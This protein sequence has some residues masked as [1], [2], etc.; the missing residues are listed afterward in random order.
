V[1]KEGFQ[2]VAAPPEESKDS[3]TFK[4]N[5]GGFL[6]AGNSRTLAFTAAADYLLRRGPSQFNVLAAVN[7]GRSSPGAG[8]PSKDTVK[9]Y[10]ARARYDY[11]FVGPLAGFLSV[12]A[13]KDKFM[14]LDLRLNIDPGVAYY[15]IDE[16]DHRFWAELGYDLQYDQRQD[17]YVALTLADD[18]LPDVKDSETSHSARLFAGYVNQLLAAVKFN[19]GIEYLQDVKDTERARLNIDLGLTSQLSTTFS[20]A[21][22]L[23][24][25]YDNAPLPGVEKTDVLSALNLVYTFSQ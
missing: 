22:T 3:T 23:G 4:V 18:T 12:S 8:Q 20:V 16:K 11:F 15:F 7:Y 9:N 5:A 17:A 25:K 2:A 6:S 19:A 1:A 10:Q 21:T 14:G 24:I 13:R